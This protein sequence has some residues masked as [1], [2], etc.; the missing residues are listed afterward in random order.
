MIELRELDKV[1]LKLAT[2]RIKLMRNKKGAQVIQMRKEI[3]QLLAAGNDR[4]ARIRVAHLIREEKMIG[5][6]DLIEI[7]C[8]LIVERLPIIESQ[9]TCPIDLKE[10]IT[11]VIF[12][13][14]RCLDITELVD[15]KK[16]FRAKYGKEF[17]T[18][19]TELIP[20]CGVSCMLV[21]KLSAVAPNI[22]TKVKVLS[23][24]AK[25]HNVDWEA[26]SFEESKPL[27]D[28]LNVPMNFE[29]ANPITVDPPKVQ[30]SNVHNVQSHQTTPN[31]PVD[32]SQQNRRF[33]SNAQNNVP[34]N[35]EQANPI[36]VDPPKVQTSN[37]HNVQS[38]QTTP[39]VPVDFSQQNRRFT[40][41][42]QNVTPVDT[43][44][45]Q[46]SYASTSHHDA[47]LTGVASGSMK[48][49]Q[50]FRSN[51]NNS[52]H[53]SDM[54]FKDATSAAHAAA[55]AAERACYAARAA[56]QL[57]GQGNVTQHDHSQ[58]Q[59][60]G[61]KESS[62]PRPSRS[63]SNDNRGKHDKLTSNT[64]KVGRK[65]IVDQETVVR[66]TKKTSSFSGAR[67]D[68]ESE[69]DDD[70]YDGPRFD[71]GF[72]DVELDNADLHVAWSKIRYALCSLEKLDLYVVCS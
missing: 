55:E 10:A 52:N 51:N 65:T 53:S 61:K 30:T 62:R 34:T 26:T 22:Q 48:K 9:K 18:A 44:S 4:T 25:E 37:V 50:L 72:D 5:A 58:R 70:D 16:N 23:D 47:R 46:S 17:V 49:K 57:A 42:A 15:V 27:D 8:E 43:G 35:F 40:S 56:A 2:A 3:A 19:A 54:K 33:T 67:R 32:F 11:S 13:T 71:A 12:A 60:I 14:P 64:K 66:E 20:G 28:L 41:N 1:S 38:H 39:N 63:H 36:T 59:T 69:S 24:I 45:S 31:V 21:E 29:Q 7:Y 68:D 6:Y